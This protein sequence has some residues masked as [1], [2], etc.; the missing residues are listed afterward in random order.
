MIMT[1]KTMKTIMMVVVFIVMCTKTTNNG[2]ADDDHINNNE[3]Q[4]NI[5]VTSHKRHGVSN[6]ERTDRLIIIKLKH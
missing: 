6:Q 2:D 4:H 3:N 1:I 5:A